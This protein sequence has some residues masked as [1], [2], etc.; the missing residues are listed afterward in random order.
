MPMQA[1]LYFMARNLVPLS[2]HHE[3][4]I[5][6]CYFSNGNQEKM[7]PREQR[8]QTPGATQTEMR[9]GAKM[10]KRLPLHYEPDSMLPKFLTQ[11]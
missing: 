1:M 5:L 4:Q 11:F 3:V 7:A 8:E 10:T 2:S 9:I 6:L